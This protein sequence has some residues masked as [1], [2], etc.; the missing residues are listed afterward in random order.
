MRLLPLFALLCPMYLL[1]SDFKNISS[2]GDSLSDS[3]NKFAVSQAFNKA[4]KGAVLAAAT[5][6]N[7]QGRASNG[8]VWTEYLA[9]MLELPPVSPARVEINTDVHVEK[10]GEKS[11]YFIHMERQIGN[12]WS[13]GGAMA[14]SGNFN[15]L[16]TSK[17][18]LS[19]SG[20]KVLPNV[21][22][23]ISNRITEKGVFDKDTIVTYMA[24]T[25]NMWYSLYGELGQT[26]FQAAEL[27]ASDIKQLIH[28]QADTI[29]LSNIPDFSMAP[30]LKE[31][32]TETKMFIRN[33]NETLKHRVE[34]IKQT[35]P[36]VNI[37][38]IDAYSFYKNIKDQVL[39]SGVYEDEA[40][41]IRM[42]NVTDA[43]LLVETGE[44]I[45]NP[46]QSMFWDGIHPTTNMH[47][48]YAK[49]VA[50]AIKNNI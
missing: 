32:S 44:I 24:G 49:Y 20:G 42:T 10:R 30:W 11:S 38:Y 35:N 12:N 34:R 39:A 6:P 9:Q 16:G 33:F 13:V 1:A 3:G 28:Y 26:G 22:S 40:L 19:F 8:R 18:V 17:D 29:V 14:L 15:N 50:D 4:T 7:W 5:Q 43:S 47:K 45:R 27:V 2:F 41:N 48:L 46:D 36:T 21:S 37:I 31:K 25:N 23:Q